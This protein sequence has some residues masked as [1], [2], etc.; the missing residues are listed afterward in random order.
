MHSVHGRYTVT[1][2]AK[3]NDNDMREVHRERAIGGWSS[4]YEQL[5]K[6][7]GKSFFLSISFL[8]TKL[9]YL[10]DKRETMS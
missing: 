8:L 4:E 7:I 1:M 9:N 3:N 10:S 6:N 2:T 5:E